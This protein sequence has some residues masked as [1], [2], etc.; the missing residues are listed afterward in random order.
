[1]IKVSDSSIGFSTEKKLNNSPKEKMS[2]ESLMKDSQ[3]LVIEKD[4]FECR[5]QSKLWK[6]FWDFRDY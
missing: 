2:M 6:K 3:I 1:M 5:E 4:E